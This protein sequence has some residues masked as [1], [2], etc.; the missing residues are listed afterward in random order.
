MT[1]QAAKS[2]KQCFGTREELALPWRPLIEGLMGYTGHRCSSFLRACLY[3]T[4][5]IMHRLGLPAMVSD[6][7]WSPIVWD[8][9]HE[10]LAE[11]KGV[12]VHSFDSMPPILGHPYPSQTPGSWLRYW[13]FPM[14]STTIDSRSLLCVRSALATPPFTRRSND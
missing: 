11:R 6:V 10:C 9:K 7:A 4:S 3:Y 14:S 13:K 1:G 8:Y 12:L 5:D 2:Q